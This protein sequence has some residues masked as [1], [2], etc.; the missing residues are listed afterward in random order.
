MKIELKRISIN[1]RMSQETTMF[2]ADLYI[3]GKM[4]GDCRNDGCGGCTNYNDNS[5]ENRKLIAECEKYCKTLP[6]VKY[7]NSECE[8]S[9]E[10]VIDDLVFKILKEKE[11]KKFTK[12]METAILFGV[13]NGYSYKSISW[14]GKKLK[15]IPLNQL[16]HT[17]DI[18]RKEKCIN[19]EVILNTNLMKL[20]VV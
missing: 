16:Q 6:K 7:G 3:N 8:Q 20:G 10:D 2:I 12:K 17:I 5:S 18:I 19:D 1:E 11:E 15:Q 13:P 9:L 14:K 4:V